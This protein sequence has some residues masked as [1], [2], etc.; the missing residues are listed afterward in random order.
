VATQDWQKAYLHQ[1]LTG[2]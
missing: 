1:N 2:T